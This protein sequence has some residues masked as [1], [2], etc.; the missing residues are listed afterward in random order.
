MSSE[1]ILRPAE[2]GD[3]QTVFEL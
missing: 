3:V 2:P 1:L